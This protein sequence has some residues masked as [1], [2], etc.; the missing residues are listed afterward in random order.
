LLQEALKKVPDN[1]TFHY[2]LG[3]TYQKERKPERARQ[4]LER[5]LQINPKSPEA[6][7]IRKALSEIGRG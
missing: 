4:H 1:P 7:E 6:A 2:H 3:L 5:A